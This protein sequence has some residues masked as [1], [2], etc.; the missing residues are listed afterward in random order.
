MSTSEATSPAGLAA[1]L[2]ELPAH[3]GEFL[4]HT[5]WRTMTQQ[6][7][8]QFAEVT[9]DHNFIH[10]D[11]E[12]AAQTQFGGTIAHGY[13]TVSLLAPISQQLLK[14]TD[15]STGINYG[16]DKVRFPAP[17]P[18]GGEFRGSAV[19]SEVGEISGGL[20][21]KLVI[22]VELKDTAKPALVAECLYR[23]FA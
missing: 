6:R 3:E 21:V 2:A 9:E 18:V 8:D 7:V 19:L 14:V 12:R 16:M 1:T 10:V 22:T 11:P 23:Y 15:A 17:L 4:G 5:A 20:Q 13:L